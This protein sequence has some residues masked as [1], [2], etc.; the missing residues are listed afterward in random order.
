MDDAS[1]DQLVGYAGELTKTPPNRGKEPRMLANLTIQVRYSAD[2][3]EIRQALDSMRS[4]YQRLE[5]KLEKRVQERL[6]KK[7][8][9]ELTAKLQKA[10]QTLEEANIIKSTQEKVIAALRARMDELTRL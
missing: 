5:E 3:D 2:D 4:E 7:K 6:T 8:L 1:L 9:E 10:Q